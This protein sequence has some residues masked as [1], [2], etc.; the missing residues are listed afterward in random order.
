MSKTTPEGKVKDAIKDHLNDHYPNW[1]YWPVSLGMGKHGVPDL[2]C[3]L[4]GKFVGIEA[5]KP[6]IRG[7]KN[8]GAT[9]LQKKELKAIR[10]SN[11]YAA[12]IDSIEELKEFLDFVDSGVRYDFEDYIMNKG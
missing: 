3:N 10:D 1:Q 12:I 9:G 5:K 4:N 2:I 7:H 8:R 6:G 11:G